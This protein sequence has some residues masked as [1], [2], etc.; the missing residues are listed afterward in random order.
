MLPDCDKFLGRRKEVAVVA[1]AEWLRNLRW[2]THPQHF[3][4][5]ECEK[6]RQ[7][8]SRVKYVLLSTCHLI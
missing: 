8:G 1:G 5:G 6:E 2:G 3:W 7:W 4:K